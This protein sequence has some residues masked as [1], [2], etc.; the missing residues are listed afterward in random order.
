MKPEHTTSDD[1]VLYRHGMSDTS[2]IESAPEDTHKRRLPNFFG[3]L[4]SPRAIALAALAIALIAAAASIAAWLRPAHEGASHSFSSQQSAQAKK[5][6]CSAYFTV[7]RAV[8]EKTP[9]PSPNDPVGKLEG[10]TNRQLVLLGGGAFLDKIVTAEP[11]APADLA[12]AVSSVSGTLEHLAVN[13]LARA[14][15]QFQ[16]VL[17]K[18]FGSEAAQVNK[19][20][21]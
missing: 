14:G 12:K 11:A 5:N 4:K 17:W 19:L 9:N 8:S 18:D 21:K 10:S 6:V 3:W 7:R 15:K 13:N 2:V 20:C 16:T 1:V